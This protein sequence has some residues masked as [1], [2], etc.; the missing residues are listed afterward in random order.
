MYGY[1]VIEQL[2]NFE[3]RLL[4]VGLLNRHAKVKG[5]VVIKFVSSK[6]TIG[7]LHIVFLHSFSR[8]LFDE[9]TP[10]INAPIAH[11]RHFRR[12]SARLISQGDRHVIQTIML[13]LD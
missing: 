10:H 7:H 12:N 8:R 13:M 9:L 6:P 2:R 4:S 1:M 11:L 3:T 5:L